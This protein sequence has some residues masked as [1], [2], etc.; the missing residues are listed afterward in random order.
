VHD[1]F[2]GPCHQCSAPRRGTTRLSGGELARGLHVPRGR[3]Q[4][5]VAER[6]LGQSAPAW[7]RCGRHGLVLL[8][9][10]ADHLAHALRVHAA[11]PGASSATAPGQSRAPR[12]PARAAA[13]GAMQRGMP[14]AGWGASRGVRRRGARAHGQ[15]RPTQALTPA[16][17]HTRD[18]AR[19]DGPASRAPH[20]PS[21]ST[22]A[23][24][25]EE[26]ATSAAASAAAATASATARHA[27]RC[28]GRGGELGRVP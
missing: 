9:L 28:C 26:A 24:E 12:A 6:R 15:L 19:P 5:K 20:L 10:L 21:V 8:R 2:R 22:C 17:A 23:A 1:H 14:R 27:F 16:R 25:R 3:G 13:R 4:A 11:E 7:R 18:A